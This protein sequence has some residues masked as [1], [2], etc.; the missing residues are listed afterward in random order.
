[1]L[2]EDEPHVQKFNARFS[3]FSSN[4]FDHKLAVAIL[5]IAEGLDCSVIT[6]ANGDDEHGILAQSSY[7][8]AGNTLMHADSD[9][10]MS[11]Q[12]PR[13]Q[14]VPTIGK[15]RY[16]IKAEK[17]YISFLPYLDIIIVYC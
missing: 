12:I 5:R 17:Y 1:M 4:A 6:N 3:F 8:L 16:Y 2:I 7:D 13:V 14:S 10:S 15:N 9:L 11:T